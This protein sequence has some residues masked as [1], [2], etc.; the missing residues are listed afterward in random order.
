MGQI[1]RAAYT[2][3]DRKCFIP[4][5]SFHW[6]SKL[7]GQSE[8]KVLGKD[9]SSLS[10]LCKNSAPSRYQTAAQDLIEN[11]VKLQGSF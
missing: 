7:Q 5:Q 1:C 3:R 2:M 8:G 4:K 6:R 9:T 11:T 10:V